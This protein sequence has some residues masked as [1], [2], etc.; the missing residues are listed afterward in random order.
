MG[1]SGERAAGD[2][3]Y[4]KVEF[5]ETITPLRV[6][7]DRQRAELIRD[8]VDAFARLR[9]SVSRF[10]AMLAP[11]AAPESSASPLNLAAQPTFAAL[12]SVLASQAR[13]SK[14]ERLREL[15]DVIERARLAEV[16][17]DVI[18]LQP[19]VASEVAL[20]GAAAELERLDA[21]FIGLCVEHVL[22]CHARDA[23]LAVMVA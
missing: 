22:D 21:A 20:R 3:R 6:S 16:H 5:A 2:F 23:S 8:V 15:D 11:D 12:L 1:E 19:P 18:F 14:F 4:R 9:G 10:I 7:G 13:Q 17:R